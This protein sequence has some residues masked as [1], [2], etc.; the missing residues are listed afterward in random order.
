MGRNVEVIVSFGGLHEKHAVPQ[1]RL[2]GPPC[3]MPSPNRDHYSC[4]QW[5]LPNCLLR[6]E[7]LRC[8]LFVLIV[9]RPVF[10]PVS[11]LVLFQYYPQKPRQDISHRIRSQGSSRRGGMLLLCLLAAKLNSF[12]SWWCCS[13]SRKAVFVCE[14]LIR[15]SACLHMQCNDHRPRLVHCML[16]QRSGAHRSS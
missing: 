3:P 13:I 16:S 4:S 1:Y 12:V 9:S 10:I 5:T 11:L 2:L 14:S 15:I 8:F 6:R 7:L